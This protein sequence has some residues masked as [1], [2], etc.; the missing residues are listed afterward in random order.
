MAWNHLISLKGYRFINNVRI[1]IYLLKTASV[2]T[3]YRITSGN[4][5][6]RQII[7]EDGELQ[8][9]KVGLKVGASGSLM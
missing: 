8:R 6:K 7:E 5:G 2:V 3:I 4:G 9:L 1:H